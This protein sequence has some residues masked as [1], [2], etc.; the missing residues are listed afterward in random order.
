MISIEFYI[1]TN[2]AVN[3]ILLFQN[4]GHRLCPYLKEVNKYR[5]IGL[6]EGNS[7]IYYVL[8]KTF[9]HVPFAQKD[10]EV[11]QMRPPEH[12]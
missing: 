11:V 3:M 2:A 6:L 10:C 9:F 4:T 5:R 12:A 8:H 1:T 7:A